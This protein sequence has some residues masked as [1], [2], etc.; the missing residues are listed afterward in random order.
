MK[1][2]FPHCVGALDGKHIIIR[3]PPD[4]GSYY[5]NYKGTHSI[6]LMALVDAN[7]EFI[8]VDVG[9]N[10]RVSDGGVWGNS[11]LCHSLKN[12][13]AGLPPDTKLTDSNRTLPYVLVGDD[14]FPLQTYLMKPFPFRDQTNEQRIFNYRLSRA[15]RV[16]EN[17]FGIMSNKF[18]IFQSPIHL[19]PSKTEIIVL[20]C[21][22]LHNLLRR[23]FAND[24][25]P[26]G[27]LDNENEENG[28]LSLGNW[29]QGQTMLALEKIARRPTREAKLVREEFTQYF[30]QEGSVP[31]QNA[32]AG[33][34]N[35]E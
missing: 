3:P 14:A 8:Y 15:R 16:S 26:P 33:I 6:V 18:R 22:A 9:T 5:Y 20:A 11:T 10:G 13:T 31:W 28:T 2:N 4:S 23:Q 32:S 7:Y 34:V 21:T 30:V 17:A 19:S 25:S 12:S 24:Y 35:D 29:R 1:W 27:L